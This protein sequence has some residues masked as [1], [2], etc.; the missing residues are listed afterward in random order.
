MGSEFNQEEPTLGS[1]NLILEV[2]RA[3]CGVTQ[4]N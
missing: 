3:F 2:E 1:H 4:K